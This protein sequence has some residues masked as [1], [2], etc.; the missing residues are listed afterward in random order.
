MHAAHFDTLARSLG[1]STRRSLVGIGLGG[2]F[3]TITRHS[4]QGQ[5]TSEP[6]PTPSTGASPVARATI[7]DNPDA[8]GLQ[9]RMP[10][11]LVASE[12]ITASDDPTFPRGARAWRVL[13]VSTGRDNTERTLVCG[14]VV[15]PESLE[16]IATQT[17]AGKRTGRVVAWCHGTLGMVHRCQ[18]SAQPA[19]EIWG[20]TPYAFNI[21]SWGSGE[22]NEPHVGSPEDGMLA[23]IIDQGWIV[24]ASDYFVGLGES[25]ALQP[26][27]VGRVAAANSIDT[28]RAAH[29]LLAQ[30]Y[31]GYATSAY[32]VVTWGHSQGGHAALWTGQLLESYAT[33]T[34]A[35]D[36]PAL[37]LSGV[38]VEAPGSNFITQ[39]AEQPN[40]A[41]GFGLLDWLANSRMSMTGVP[42]P[43]PAAPF[44]FSY[45]FGSWAE[46][47]KS[48]SADAAQM[49]AFPDV[50]P[51]DLT[52]IV[53][54]EALETIKG[55]NQ[56]CWTAEDGARLVALTTPFADR[57]FLQSAISEGEIIDGFQHGNLDALCA[58][59][60]AP[61]V[62][63]WCEWLRFN[64]P[65]PLGKHPMAKLPRRG[66]RLAPVMI[67][68]G[69]ADT[70]VHCVTPQDAEDA[71]PTAQDCM[72]VA[73][74]DALNAE[75]CPEG[76]SNGHLALMIWRPES[77]ITLADHSAI[78]A[79]PGAASTSDL[80][81]AGSP[82]QQFFIGAFAGSLE[83]GCSAT[84][85]NATGDA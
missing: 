23:G 12:E 85:V 58:G 80:S 22:N 78:A 53:Q 59:A 66:D 52:A 10:G 79:L 15:A 56:L 7:C 30:V 11:E 17:V 83:P 71:V 46:F 75:Y 67:A 9:S 50:G 43:I 57:P 19:A 32:D 54:P 21:I 48:G 13:Y 31:D 74:Y 51:L 81:F 29:H 65:G 36:D 24:T 76:V 69:S 68:H 27:V 14:V 60:P 3:A 4:A 35:A 63:A 1:S 84:V 82:L 33:A 8:T 44:F 77:G 42:E 38:A 61:E 20:A 70:V 25:D 18:P 55:V 34:A 45:L 26:W 39:P 40:A 2:L 73:L 47:S 28:I 16:R 49:P 5:A 41:P 6:P 37:A 62:R 64:L 72:S